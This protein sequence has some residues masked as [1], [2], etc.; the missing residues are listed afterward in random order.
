MDKNPT[1]NDPAD[2]AKRWVIENR[3]ALAHGQ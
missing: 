2:Q 1:V 3:P